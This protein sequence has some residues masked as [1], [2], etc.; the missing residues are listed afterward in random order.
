MQKTT[1]SPT[2]SS[3]TPP[4]PFKLRLHLIRH[5]ETIANV[6]NI[7]LGQGD[8]PLTSNGVAVAQMFYNNYYSKIVD[9]DFN[10]NND[11]NIR[12]AAA[13]ASEGG[14][15]WRTY[16][17]DLHRAHRTAKIALGLE[18]VHG[19]ELLQQHQRDSSQNDNYSSNNINLIVDPRLRELAKGAREGYRKSFSYEEALEA[20]RSVQQASSL[21]N[22]TTAAAAEQQSKSSEELV[23][24]PLLESADDAWI[25]VKDWIDSLVV[26]AAIE[27]HD[28]TTAT[29]SNDNSSN[30]NKDTTT[31]IYNVFTLS[32]SALI[33]TMIYKMAESQLSS[34]QY[35]FNSEGKLWL[36]NLSR[37]VIDVCP[38]YHCCYDYVL[39]KKTN[40]KKKE[41]IGSSSSSSSSFDNC[42]IDGNDEDLMNVRRQGRIHDL[43]WSSNLVDLAD[44]SH[45]SSDDDDDDADLCHG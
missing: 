39:M 18:D 19:N 17:S 22:A 23:D 45:L 7:V 14:Y 44:T 41:R 6:Q 29:N 12:G 8:S 5:G 20:R 37:T 4:P 16:C 10:N 13:T 38:S 43:R 34:F 15:Y 11:N 9:R 27:H 24:I 30:I 2:T 42:S 26:D 28:V 1:P 32:H 21:M 40:K 33:R 36:P 3:P 31:K 35:E 25:R